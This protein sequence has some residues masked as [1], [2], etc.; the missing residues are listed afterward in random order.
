MS[1]TKQKRKYPRVF[2][3][4]TKPS[5]T[6]QSF[7]DECNINNIMAKFQKTGAL[8][9][10]AKHA[11]NYGDATHIELADALNV[12]ADAESMFE[13]LPSSLRKR[14][15]NS[16]E[17]FLEFVNDEKNLEEMKKLGLV[18]SPS[19]AKPPVK[20]SERSDTPTDKAEPAGKA[21]AEPEAP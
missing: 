19:P 5:M 13:E 3:K 8:N 9:H 2:A 7:K 1:T 18:K 14:F 11:P 21:K 12:V 10:Y 6:K 15:Q 17:L 4:N 16:P 20:V